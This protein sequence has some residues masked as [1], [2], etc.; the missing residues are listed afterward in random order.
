MS[1]STKIAK[2]IWGQ[3]AARCCICKR[4]LIKKN[5]RN[6]RKL[7]LV[8]EIA[9][10][11]GSKKSAPRGESDLTQQERDDVDNLM[12][13]CQEHHKEIDDADNIEDYSVQYL[14]NIKENHIKWIAQKFLQEK[15]WRLKF[16]IFFY[17]NIPR[18]AEQAAR[19]GQELNLNFFDLNRSLHSLSYE[20]NHVMLSF[21]NTLTRLE[22]SSIPIKEIILHEGLEGRLIS[23][24]QNRFRTKNINFDMRNETD[25]MNVKFTGDWNKDPH[26]YTNLNN[27]K[28]IFPINPR[29]I[30]TTTAF[31]HF[32]PSGGHNSFSGLGIVTSVDY[33]NSIITVTPFAIGQFDFFRA[34]MNNFGNATDIM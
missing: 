6:S 18:L 11:V 33:V 26:I 5:E 30:T 4:E 19:L 3:C 7:T 28:V 20:L 31:V 27:F 15:P 1:I 34:L 17:L 23:F 8:G 24:E 22:I 14:K 10:I 12:L 32:R 9:H 13:L 16:S 29:W 2:I 25:L 21:K